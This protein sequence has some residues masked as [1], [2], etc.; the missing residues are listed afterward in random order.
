MTVE[1]KHEV[2]D[3]DTGEVLQETT[4]REV[5]LPAEHELTEDDYGM[6]KDAGVATVIVRREVDDDDNTSL[7]MSTLLNTLKKDPTHSS[8]EAL[9]H[10]YETLRERRGARRRRGARAPRPPVLLATSATTWAPSAG[11][12]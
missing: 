7:D 10:L 4:E 9:K 6:L 5:I 11:T 1:V 8:D 3:E 2:I 12:G